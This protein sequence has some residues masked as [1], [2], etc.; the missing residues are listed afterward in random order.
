MFLSL[1]KMSGIHIEPA[2]ITVIAAGKRCHD[3]AGEIDQK[4]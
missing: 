1:C 4:T 3:H 2:H